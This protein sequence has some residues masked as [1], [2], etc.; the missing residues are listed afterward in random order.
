VRIYY[1]SEFTKAIDVTWLM[2]PVFIWSTIEPS[3]AIVSACLPHLAPL[4]QLVHS[5]ISSSFSSNKS[6]QE[7]SSAPWRSKSR[8]GA[9]QGSQKGT[10]LFTYGGGG[11]RFNF[12]VGGGDRMLK[13]GESD[14]EIGL[15][16][17]VTTGSGGPRKAHSIESGSDDNV[18]VHVHDHSI[19][20]QSSFVQ[21][22]TSIKK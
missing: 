20:V 6:G 10:P 4:A 5:K 14:D 22:T 2:G 8:S 11:S 21:S 9:G 13:L 16:N 18:H 1:L 19:V 17:H 7:L 12:G 3:I 15:T